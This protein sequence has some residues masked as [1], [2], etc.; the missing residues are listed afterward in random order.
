MIEH[1]VCFK[2]KDIN[3]FEEVGELFADLATQIPEI[4]SYKYEKNVYTKRES[5]MDALLKVY[6]KNEEDLE[7]YLFDK[8]HVEFAQKANQEYWTAVFTTDTMVD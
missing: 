2:L 1:I 4:Q 5:N 3:K 8:K 7:T 6:F